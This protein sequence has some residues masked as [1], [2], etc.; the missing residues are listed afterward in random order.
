M[1]FIKRISLQ[2]AVLINITIILIAILVHSLIIFQVLPYT[3]VSGGFSPTFEMQKQISV[4][5]T[6]ILCV[7]IPINL[8]AYKK[9]LKKK[10]VIVLKILLYILF[11]YFFFGFFMQLLGTIFERT[12]M[13]ILCLLSAIMY[14]RLAIEKNS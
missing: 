14:L 7:T 9:I 11:A 3:W 5:S 10:L 8:L 6:M 12:L 4:I 13:S 2:S 1:K